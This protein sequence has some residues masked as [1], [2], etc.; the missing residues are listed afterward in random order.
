MTIRILRAALALALITAMSGCWLMAKKAE[1]MIGR[2]RDAL[3]ES[4]GPPMQ[5]KPDGK[6]GE[7]WMYVEEASSTSQG[8]VKLS[9]LQDL[10]AMVSE[11]AA[12]KLSHSNDR[13]TSTVIKVSQ[14]THL[15]WFDKRGK[16]IK[17]Y[18]IEPT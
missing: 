17:A 16:V 5:A 1:S 9:S 11:V 18:T 2:D 3:F 10:N 4:W 12:G 15:F 7:V 6:G 8:G 13:W 14:R